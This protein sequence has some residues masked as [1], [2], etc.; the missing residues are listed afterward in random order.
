MSNII[1]N[2]LDV[3]LEGLEFKERF[4]LRQVNWLFHVRALRKVAAVKI[5][6][7]FLCNVNCCSS[8]QPLRD[9]FGQ[10][11]DCNSG[12]DNDLDSFNF[13]VE[14]ILVNFV[15][16]LISDCLNELSNLKWEHDFE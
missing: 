2:G 7:Y 16:S 13:I 5:V 1:D 11:S 4:A 12:S 6:P 9:H 10:N 8:E 15:V 14:C 3:F